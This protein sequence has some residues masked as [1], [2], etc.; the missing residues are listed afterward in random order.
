MQVFSAKDVER[1]LGISKSA[2]RALVRGG[3]VAPARGRHRQYVFSFR[4]LATLRAARSLLRVHVPPHRIT[5]ALAQFRSES[6]PSNVRACGT[7]LVVR[8]ECGLWRNAEG[9]FLLQLDPTAAATTES[10]NEAAAPALEILNGTALNRAANEPVSDEPPNE[11]EAL[12]GQALSLEDQDTNAAIS[13]YR[14]CLEIDPSHGDARLNWG[15]LLH[16]SG[17]HEEAEAVYRGGLANGAEDDPSLLFNLALVLEDT[18]RELEAIDC[19]KR[20]LARD[21]DQADVHL[22]LARLYQ[23]LEMPRAAIRHWNEF[24]RISGPNAPQP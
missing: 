24:R 18:G 9:Q 14:L 12:F 4:D 19:Y 22:N 5:G 20:A 2:L 17:L 6:G 13:G 10:L 3:F 8:D 21:P 15:R 16:S 1:V 11:A 23:Q 7:E